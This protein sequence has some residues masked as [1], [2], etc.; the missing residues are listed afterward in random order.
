VPSSRIGEPMRG[1]RRPSSASRPGGPH[2]VVGHAADSPSNPSCGRVD[3]ARV[4]EGGPPCR[5]RC[6]LR[7]KLAAR[8]NSGPLATSPQQAAEWG[9]PGIGECRRAPA[10]G[11]K[12]MIGPLMVPIDEL[13]RCR[14]KHPVERRNGSCSEPTG[15]AGENRTHP[16]GAQAHQ[17]VGPVGHFAGMKRGAA[18]AGQEHQLQVP[19]L[20]S[21]KRGVGGRAEGGS[22]FPSS[23]IASTPFPWRK[24]ACRRAPPM[25]GLG[26]DPG[27]SLD[28]VVEAASSAG[29]KRGGSGKTPQSRRVAGRGPSQEPGFRACS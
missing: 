21:R 27:P 28:G 12:S 29:R 25:A 14:T 26:P 16:E 10:P 4:E 15:R 24:A 7:C 6:R 1:W 20:P 19:I 3:S 13:I 2:A 17:S 8:C 9:Q 23:S 18:V 22:R 5:D 11:R